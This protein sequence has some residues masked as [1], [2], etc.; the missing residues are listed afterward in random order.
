MNTSLSI[1]QIQCAVAE[2]FGVRTNIIVPNV[3][4]GFF[5][6]HEA[7]MVV[8]SK[9]GY[10][11]EVEIKRS[12]EDFKK[13]FQKTTNHDEGKVQWKFFAVP[14]N[15]KEKVLEYLVAHNHKDWGVIIYYEDG[16]AGFEKVPLYYGRPNPKNK[17][18]L[19]E[20]LAI[21]R[22]GCMRIWGLKKKLTDKINSK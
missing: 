12:W 16:S 8:I 19:E 22:L 7:D 14:L 3:S 13:D 2:I 6:T 20:T 11:T 10:L 9:S 15:L 5:A 4:W 17:L 18:F 1:D 21:A